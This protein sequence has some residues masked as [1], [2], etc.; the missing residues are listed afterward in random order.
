M[1]ETHPAVS[2]HMRELAK[3]SHQAVA[4]KYGPDHFKKMNAA[5][6]KNRPKKDKNGR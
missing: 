5:R 2:A 4:K 6:W 1:T 3:K